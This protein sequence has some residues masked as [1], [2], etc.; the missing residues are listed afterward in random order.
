[1]TTTLAPTNGAPL[2]AADNPLSIITIAMQHGAP[3]EQ[4]GQLL[5]LQERWE[6]HRAAEAFGAAIASFQREC[7]PIT[8]ARKVN[9][10]PLNYRFASYDDV[11]RVAGPLLA[12]HGIAVSFTTESTERGMRAVC[13]VRVGIH[14]EDYA[15]E[16]PVPDMRVNDTQKYGAALSYVKRYALCAALNIVVTDEDNDA[17]PLQRGITHEQGE[18]LK[19]LIQQTDTDPAKFL[20]WAGCESLAEMPANKFG[21]AVAFLERKLPP[22]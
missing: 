9:A 2:P 21:D 15:L 17:I 10:G 7:P 18:K 11:M 14:S 8:K 22:V 4:L 16:I 6:R 20:K 5:D 12:S 13:R 1:M 19:R 3:P